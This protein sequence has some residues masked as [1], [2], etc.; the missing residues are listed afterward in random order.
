MCQCSRLYLKMHYSLI[1]G[2]LAAGLIVMVS[3]LILHHTIADACSFFFIK[4]IIGLL[5][6]SLPHVAPVGRI[7]VYVFPNKQSISKKIDR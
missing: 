6:F 1:F 7:L 2:H 5:Q 4:F 3:V